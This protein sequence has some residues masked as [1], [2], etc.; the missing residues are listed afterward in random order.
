MIVVSCSHGIHLGSRIARRLK[1]GHAAL[2]ASK[3][4]DG[5]LDISFTGSPRGKDVV[6][7]QSFC[8]DINELIVETIFAAATAREL[9]AKKITLAAPYFPYF[10]QDKRFRKG[11]CVSLHVIGPLFD[12]YFDR[13]IVIDPHL[14]RET[15]LKHVFR[16][17][18]LRLTSNPLIADYIK[19][20]FKNPVL[21]GPDWESYKWA[22]K[23]AEMINAES[24][25]L[26][27]T[28]YSS[29]HVK[30]RLK[31]K[32]NLKNRTVVIVDD[33]ISTG[34]TIL[35]TIKNIRKLKPKRIV[36]ICVHGIFAENSLA[37]IRNAGALVVATNTIPSSV[38]KIDVGR[39]LTENL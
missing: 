27:K 3:F 12:R 2:K 14:H 33:I 21:I 28:R 10:R 4:P 39:L 32:I 1:A 23:V 15:T 9:G 26:E 25:I 31:D 16:K 13:I 29:H 38:A 22:R 7:V 34:H 35:E 8:G 18:S 5:E 37:K 11:E 20:H 36:C 17:P 30:V 19:K 6:L 24:S